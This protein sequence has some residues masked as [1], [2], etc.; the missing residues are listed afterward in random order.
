M[1]NKKTV[2]T[3]PISKSRKY[4]SVMRLMMMMICLIFAT[5]SFAQLDYGKHWIGFTDKQGSNY[6]IQQ[7]EAFLSQKAI[8]RRAR[9][10]IPIQENDLPVNPNYINQIKQ[11]GVNVLYTSKWFNSALIAVND[12]ATLAQINE[13][14]FV[15]ATEGVSKMNRPRSSNNARFRVKKELEVTDK[16]EIYYGSAFKQ[17]RMLYGDHLH[18]R[19]YTGKGMTIA[20]MDAGFSNVDE[21]EI[22]QPL[23]INEQ[24]LG[25]RDFVE[26]DEDVYAHSSH[27]TQVFST[28]AANQEGVYVGAAPD[29]KYWLFRTEDAGSETIVEEYNWVRAAEF[30]DSAGVDIINT[31]LGYSVFDDPAM[32]YTYDDMNGNTC[33]IT[34]GA[35]IAASKGILVVSSAGNQGNKNWR[36]ITAPADADSVLTVGAVDEFEH[37]ASFSSQGPTPDQRVKPNIV[38]QGKHTALVLPS[39]DLRTGNGTSYAAPIIAGLSACLWQANR[40]KNN[41]DIIQAIEKSS[42]NYSTPNNLTGYGLPN[43]YEAFLNVTGDEQILSFDKDAVAFVY[44]NPFASQANIYYYSKITETVQLELC[45]FSGRTLETYTTDVFEGQPY[46]FTFNWLNYPKG[47][48]LVKITNSN[49][50]KILRAV[51]MGS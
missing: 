34:R 49:Q 1:K 18:S 20:V 26:G 21:L 33:R 16:N 38:A 25:T 5:N 23:F 46:K 12:S 35:D 15:E 47:M 37:Y 2:E 51:K 45:T 8:E 4:N 32:N 44:P 7:P 19:G 9:Y 10:N 42:D 13:L 27:G 43:F 31:S 24:I 11:L 48:F 36:Y 22:F 6:S 28:M 14:P 17:L 30:A 39:G 29:A 3:P 50:Q 41:M 40:G